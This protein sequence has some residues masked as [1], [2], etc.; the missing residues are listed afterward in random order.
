MEELT[1][2]LLKLPQ[3]FKQIQ[4]TPS[5]PRQ[6]TYCELCTGDHPIGFYPQADEEANYMGNQQQ[7]EARYQSNQGYEHRNNV[8]YGQR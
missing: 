6:I 3:Q 2:Q 7:R 1:K 4:E 5:K 8:N